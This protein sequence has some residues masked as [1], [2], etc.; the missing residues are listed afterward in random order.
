MGCCGQRRAAAS[1][2][3]H[4]ARREE[5]RNLPGRQ[6]VAT[7]RLRYLGE[8]PVH[9]RGTVT[10]MIYSFVSSGAIVEIDG[11]DRPGL[12]RTRQFEAV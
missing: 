8:R 10:G 2:T 6:P 12:V 3:P 11:R 9:V 1:T 5:S 4:R 7:V